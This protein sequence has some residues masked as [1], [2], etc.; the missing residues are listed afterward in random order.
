MACIEH[1][2]YRSKLNEIREIYHLE[3]EKYE[4]ACNEFTSHVMSLLKEQSRTRHSKS[5]TPELNSHGQNIHPI[6]KRFDFERI[7]DRKF[8]T[9]CAQ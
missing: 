2:D 5:S 9:L 4:Q 6:G 7:S 3:L 8:Y 1:T